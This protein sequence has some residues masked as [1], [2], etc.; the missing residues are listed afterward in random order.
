MHLNLFIF[1]YLRIKSYFN[2]IELQ[3]K[4]GQGLNK[5]ANGKNLKI[6]VSS[7]VLWIS[8][9]SVLLILNSLT[10]SFLVY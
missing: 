7:Y 5:N 4:E 9:V 6:I 1:N 10:I 2:D 3:T 8:D